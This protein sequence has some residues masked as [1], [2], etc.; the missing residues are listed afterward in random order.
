LVSI[1][2]NEVT[3]PQTFYTV[4]DK[5]EL[6]EEIDLTKLSGIEI[7]TVDWREIIY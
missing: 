6:P 3:R 7:K 2:T 1:L 5:N 4:Y